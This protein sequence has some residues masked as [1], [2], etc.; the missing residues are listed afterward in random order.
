MK[1][2]VFEPFAQRDGHFGV[3]TSQIC[4]ELSRLG[5]SVTLVTSGL[6]PNRFLSSKPQ[7]QI[8]ETLKGSDAGEGGRTGFLKS[9]FRGLSL[10]LDNGRV[11]FEL[12]RVYRQRRFDV[13]HFFDYEPVSTVVLLWFFSIFLRTRLNPLY[14]VFHAPD[15]SY[16]GH[17]NL[18]YNL[19]GIISRPMLRILLDR[20]AT[21]ITAHGNWDKKELKKILGLERTENGIITVPYGAVIQKAPPSRGEARAKLGIEYNGTLLLF[22]GM[23]RRDKG[24]E[25]LI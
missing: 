5:H 16:Q 22:F 20:H 4:Q 12:F 15:P 25:I 19:Y 18:L 1:I 17:G 2:L 9:A 8:I 10:I 21:A 11:L 14:M 7:F 3:Y 24:V 13:V 23:L 6:F